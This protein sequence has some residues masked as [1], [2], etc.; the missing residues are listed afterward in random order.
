[1]ISD[2]SG[3]NYSV[4]DHRIESDV[5]KLQSVF[6]KVAFTKII[7]VA[8]LVV[9]AD[10]LLIVIANE[11]VVLRVESMIDSHVH[12]RIRIWQR[13]DRRRLSAQERDEV[14]FRE[15]IGDDRDRGG[16]FLALKREEKEGLVVVIGSGPSFAKARKV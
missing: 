13:Y 4:A 12:T 15:R 10:I 6:C 16:L 5:G 14:Q 2:R 3:I 9:P 1:M 8:R 7:S 11:H